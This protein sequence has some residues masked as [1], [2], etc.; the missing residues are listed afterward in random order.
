VGPQGGAQP[1]GVDR[2]A[3]QGPPA[4]IERPLA[5]VLGVD[6]LQ[7]GH[8]PAGRD[9][10]AGERGGEGR[11]RA[12]RRQAPAV[13]I[14]GE[15]RAVQH[16]RADPAALGPAVG[17]EGA[18]EAA[19]GVAA[20][21]GPLVLVAPGD[22]PQRRRDLGEILAEVTAVVGVGR[23]AERA[24]VLAQIE[25]VEVVPL[26]VESVG[27]VDLEEVVGVAVDVQHGPSRG[28]RRTPPHQRGADRAVIIVGEPQGR[29][30][31]P[32]QDIRAPARPVIAVHRS[33]RS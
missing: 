29:R 14:E 12:H 5:P 33:F 16:E 7:V 22:D 8:R 9:L 20:Q 3:D 31:E 24:A 15:E 4:Q 6:A 13:E 25:R 28:R 21:R 17:V 27:Q 18:R 23:V 2:E 11:Q 26:R 1:V 19:G 10:R 30:V 32:R